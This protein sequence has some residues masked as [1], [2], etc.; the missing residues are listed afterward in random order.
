MFVLGTHKGGLNTNSLAYS[1]CGTML[2][3]SGGVVRVWDLRE[4]RQLREIEPEGDPG[5]VSFAP[6][7]TLLVSSSGEYPVQVFDPAR[8]EVVRRFGHSWCR[9]QCAIASGDGKTLVCGGHHHAG[10]GTVGRIL[11]WPMTGGRGRPRLPDVPGDVGYAALSPDGRLLAAGSDERTAWV[12]D[13]KKREELATFTC[14]ASGWRI[15]AFAPDGR[16]LAVTAGS[17]IELFDAE[18]WA[19]ERVLRG[20]KRTVYGVVYAA[21]GRLVSC[22]QDGTVRVWDCLT[23]KASAALSWDM[24]PVNNVCVSPDGMTAAAGAKKGRIVVWDLD[25]A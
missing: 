1:P 19:C 23:G 2:A 24:G 20:H 8:G 10:G 17:T 18:T 11:I 13:L 21:D 16:Q 6:D 12:W 5:S 15:V 7:G 3:S 25:A 22:G 9:A 14:R 4:R